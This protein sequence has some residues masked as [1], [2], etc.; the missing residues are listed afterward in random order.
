MNI[1]E[2]F[3]KMIELRY[4]QPSIKLWLDEKGVLKGSTSY[5]GTCGHGGR[6]GFQPSSYG[7]LI[8]ELFNHVTENGKIYK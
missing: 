4:P 1:S 5:Y 7:E 3:K 8:Q 2:Y 6:S